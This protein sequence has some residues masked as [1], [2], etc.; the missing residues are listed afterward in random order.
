MRSK[1]KGEGQHRLLFLRL[2]YNIPATC[3]SNMVQHCIASVSLSLSLAEITS[4]KV[5]SIICVTSHNNGNTMA[6]LL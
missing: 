6:K 5:T 3:R 4:L 1:R 2:T